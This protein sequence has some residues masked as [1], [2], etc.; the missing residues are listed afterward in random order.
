MWRGALCGGAG[1]KPPEAAARRGAGENESDDLTVIRGIGIASQNRLH[2]AG[3][4]T[5]ADLA[6]TPPEEV[7]R[8]LGKLAR[9]AKVDEWI[10]RARELAGKG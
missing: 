3:I 7:R 4:K 10:S 8:R 5:Y 9:G 1:R 6:S 2:V